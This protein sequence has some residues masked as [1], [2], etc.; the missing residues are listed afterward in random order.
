MSNK[1]EVKETIF[2]DWKITSTKTPMYSHTMMEDLCTKLKVNMLPEMI[3]E[4][5]FK[6][7]H[8]KTNFTLNFNAEDAISFSLND[9]LEKTQKIEKLKVGHAWKKK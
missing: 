1:K 9:I 4:S 2:E 3:F 6:F 7:E 5:N 8:K